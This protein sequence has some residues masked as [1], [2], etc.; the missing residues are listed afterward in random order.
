VRADDT[1][2]LIVRAIVLASAA[3]EH[4]Y[5]PYSQFRVGAAVATADGR[6]FAGANVENASFGLTAC[7]ER[8][9]LWTGTVAGASDFILVVV[10]TDTRQPVTPCGACRQV[11]SELAPE[12]LVVMTTLGGLRQDAT[13]KE[14]LPGAFGRRDLTS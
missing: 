8:V 14:L 5:A 7:A 6:L 10:V 4:A 12:A 2:E 1:N 9:A 11:L 13:V 3:R